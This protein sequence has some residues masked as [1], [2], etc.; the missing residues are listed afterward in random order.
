MNAIQV[1]NVGRIKK[2]TLHTWPSGWGRDSWALAGQNYSIFGKCIPLFLG[3]E[4]YFD[5]QK[6]VL[7]LPLKKRLPFVRA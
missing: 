2:L 5:F 7:F 6:Q 4:Y 1:I 3:E